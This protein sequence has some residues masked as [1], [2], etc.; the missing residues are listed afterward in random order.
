MAAGGAFKI[1]L[2]VR[3]SQY[4]PAKHRRRKAKLGRTPF[5]L[6][7]HVTQPLERPGTP[8]IVSFQLSGVSS[9]VSS[10]EWSGFGNLHLL[11]PE[12]HQAQTCASD[13]GSN[14]ALQPGL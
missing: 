14:D 8:T 13:K 11:K 5:F 7:L 10:A 1:T 6:F 9:R 2:L 12:R 4:E 3:V